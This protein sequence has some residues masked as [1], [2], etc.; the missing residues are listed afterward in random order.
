MELDLFTSWYRHSGFPS[1]NQMRPQHCMGK[2]KAVGM[3]LKLYEPAWKRGR[4]SAL[5]DCALR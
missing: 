4:R 1:E 2:M 3:D 5:E